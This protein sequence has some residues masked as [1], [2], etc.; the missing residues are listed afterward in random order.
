MAA[1]SSTMFFGTREEDRAQ[2]ITKHSA[3]PVSSAS[4]TPAAQKKRRNQPGTPS[5]ALGD[6]TGIKKHYS[7]KHGEK[8]YKCDKCA[9]KYAV[10]SDWKAHSKTC[11]S[12]EHRC[13]CGTLFSRA[14]DSFRR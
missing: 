11:G 12:R 8:K 6:L 3:A 9:K 5:K 13:D 7:R 10:H 2:M 1:S 14:L 4:P